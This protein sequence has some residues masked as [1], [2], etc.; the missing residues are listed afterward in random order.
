MA[1]YQPKTPMY[2]HQKA[3]VK[4]IF[5]QFSKDLGA[6]LL[7]E[8]RTGKT[9]ASVDTATILYKKY[10]VRKIV[11]IAP[12]RVLGVWVKEFALHSSLVVN[13]IIWDADARKQPIPSQ[14]GCYDLEMVIVNYEAF[15]TPGKKTP[16]WR[17][18]KTTGRFKHRAMLKAWV[19]DNDALLIVDEGH[20]LKNPSGK[21]ANMIISMRP[22][23]KYRLLLT[24]TPITKAKR[25]HDVYMLW[26][27]VNPDRFREWG[28]TVDQ[29]KNHIGRW[30]SSNG[31]PQWV[32]PRPRGI[33]DLKRGLHQDGMVVRRDECFDLPK[34]DERVISVPLKASTRF[35]DDMADE[36]ITK[37]DNG[38][39]AEASIPLVVT[40]RLLQ[41]TSGFVGVRTPHPTKPDKFL[42]VAHRVGTEKLDA[43]R[44]LLV[45]EV[46]E[47]DEKVVI[48][49]RFKMD[50][51]S[52]E[53]LCEELGIKSWSIR[54]G[55]HRSVTDDNVRAFA[56]HDGA[57]A[58]IVQPQ[59]AALGIDLS[60]AP[61]MI[62]FSLTSS[63][64][65]FQQ[66][67]D[68]I[69][70]SR[71][72]TTFTYLL[73]EGTVDE[74]VKDALKLD[75]QVSKEILTNHQRLRRY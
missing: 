27:M 32:G 44:E 37:L 48:V 38:E 45:E 4:F 47:R 28:S 52:I 51:D 59:A 21:A 1:V 53:K 46:I 17:R 58:M 2:A 19:G 12:N 75:G 25:A 35:Y 55:L 16:S 15:G 18:S 41:I 31:Y 10:G 54:G 43:L 72:S 34:S 68:R 36:M 42:T 56:Q 14:A 39:I 71:K 8:P 11:V 3:G 20:K 23:F 64:V 22:M 65:D 50:L 66:C 69:A 24:G 74:L 33:A 30:I 7:W 13:T 40:L 26:Q 60:T 49:A 73:A 6:A 70:L 67:K 9:K 29:F 5:S 57:G 63:W 62:W 61:Q